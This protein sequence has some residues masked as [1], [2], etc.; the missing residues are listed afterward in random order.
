MKNST[1]NNFDTEYDAYADMIYKIAYMYTGN[2]SESEDI[3][4]EVF[5]KLLY[6]GLRFTSEEHKKAWLIRTVSNQCKDYLKSSRKT[7]LSL[8]DNLIS[9]KSADNDKR[10]DIRTKI[11]SLNPKYKTVIYLYYYEGYATDEIAS[12]LH[13]SASAVKMRLKRAREE[14]K[15]ELEGYDE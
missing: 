7:N 11:I 5:I 8:D 1:V 6:K 15:K 13:I 4:Q 12:I 3:V 2:S 14:L 10:L 9:D